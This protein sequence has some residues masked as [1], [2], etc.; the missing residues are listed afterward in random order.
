MNGIVSWIFAGGVVA[1]LI[2]MAVSIVSIFVLRIAKDCRVVRVTA[3]FVYLAALFGSFGLVMATGA[4]AWYLLHT[5]LGIIN[6]ASVFLAFLVVVM[7][8]A[9]LFVTALYA[10]NRKEQARTRQN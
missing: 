2:C 8:T 1:A 6:W 5:P 3:I 7:V 9:F 10:S 4:V